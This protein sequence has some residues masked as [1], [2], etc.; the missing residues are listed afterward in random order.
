MIR[1]RRPLATIAIVV[2]HGVCVG[3]G[4]NTED[5]VVAQDFT[6]PMG[7]ACTDTLDCGPVAFCAKPSCGAPHGEC[8]LRPVLCD[9]ASAVTC[10]CDGVNYWNDCL[11]RQNGIAAMVPGQCT[12]QYVTCGGR[13]GTACPTA[14]AFCARLLPGG[15]GPCD[16]GLAGACWVLP[17]HCTGGDAGAAEWESCGSRSSSCVDICSAIRSEAPYRQGNTASC[18]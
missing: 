11:R 12:A 17:P 6:Q 7:G 14:G 8:Q 15:S 5:V 9:E 1:V 10:G 16:P 2:A 18:P 4:C 13:R 3:G